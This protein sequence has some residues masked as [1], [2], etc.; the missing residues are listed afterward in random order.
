MSPGCG[1]PGASMNSAWAPTLNADSP[2]RSGS[3]AAMACGTGTTGGTY[4]ARS[5][6]I[7]QWFTLF[8]SPG[9]VAANCSSSDCVCSPSSPMPSVAVGL[10]GGAGC[11]SVGRDTDSAEGRPVTESPSFRRFRR[12]RGGSGSSV[13]SRRPVRDR[14]PF[15]A[16][17]APTAGALSDRLPCVARRMSSA[18][19]RRKTRNPVRRTFMTGAKLT[20]IGGRSR[21]WAGAF[22]LHALYRPFSLTPQGLDGVLTT[23]RIHP[24]GLTSHCGGQDGWVRDGCVAGEVLADVGRRSAVDEW[25]AGQQWRGIRRLR[26]GWIAHCD[27]GERAGRGTCSSDEGGR[28]RIA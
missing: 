19:I 24:A 8:G 1:H 7:G 22:C 12:L 13:W 3:V 5:R 25:S 9:K 27:R 23:F 26:V 11:L 21:R 2:V 15:E 28:G 6:S 20:S 4:G 10:G 16:V 18:T 17:R 14:D